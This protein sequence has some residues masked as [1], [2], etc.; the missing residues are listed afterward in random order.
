MGGHHPQGSLCGHKLGKHWIDRG[1]NCRARNT[2]PHSAGHLSA[3]E[4]KRRRLATALHAQDARALL[5]AQLPVVLDNM[6]DE[7]IGQVQMVLDAAVIDPELEKEAK[8]YRDRAGVWTAEGSAIWDEA[9]NRKADRIMEGYIRFGAWDQ[10]IRLDYKKLME[11]N[12]LNP[13]TDNPDEATYLDSIQ[14]TLEKRGVWLQYG[15]QMVRDPQDPS[16][17]IID[18]RTFS[19]W[20]TLGPEGDKIPTKTGKLTRD[21]LLDTTELG[22]GYYER[23]YLGPVQKALEREMARLDNQIS[24]GQ[25]QHMALRQEHIHSPIVATVSDVLGGASFPDFSIWDPPFR[26]LLRA[27]ELNAGGNVK[28]SQALLVTAAILARTCAQAIAEYIDKTTTGAGRAVA[29]LK[30]LKIAGE[31]AQ[32]VLLVTGVVAAVSRLS[33]AA[34][35]EGGA[36]ATS[37]V[38]AL[39][40]KIVDKAVADNPELA[41]DLA[42][43]R[44][45]RGP[46]GSIC[47]F[48]KGNHSYGLSGGGWQNWP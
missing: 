2:S 37:E 38:D 4:V 17:R 5:K 18:P 29:G 21:A 47:G 28:A 13:I 39:A 48:V 30:V 32:V 22:A 24:T 3:A 42:S 25:S 41:K 15:A 45:V 34:A 12:A 16:S 43:V 10:R 20:L 23:V 1:T 36:G 31:I 46:K 44:W 26:M 19:V 9:S 40:K 33:V 35:V 27:R 7:Q 14:K 6:S 8:K 11:R